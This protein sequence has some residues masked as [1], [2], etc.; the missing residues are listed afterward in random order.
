MESMVG[1]PSNLEIAETT[2]E[3]CYV[4]TFPENVDDRGFFFRKYCKASFDFFG[5]NS[6]WLQ[7]NLSYNVKKGTLR[8]F[9]Y[10]K[11]PFGEVKLVTCVNGAI[12]DCIIDLRPESRS[13]MQTF[14]IELHARNNRSIY[15]PTGVAHAYLTLQNESTVLYQVSTEYTKHETAG[16]RF[17]DRKI[18][19]KWPIKPIVI[20]EQDLLWEDL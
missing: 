2:I 19:V 5:L 6:R 10:Q 3:G 20:S 17:N 8:G 12:F 9:H 11:E 18:S 1:N 4:I 7:T 14:G 16:I 13:F 15:I